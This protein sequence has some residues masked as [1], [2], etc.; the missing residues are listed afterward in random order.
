LC[1][2]DVLRRLWQRRHAPVRQHAPA[3]NPKKGRTKPVPTSSSR[4]SCFALR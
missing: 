3:I 4:F 2:V 1:D